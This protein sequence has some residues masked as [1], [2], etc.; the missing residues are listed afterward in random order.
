MRRALKN[1]LVV[2]LALILGGSPLLSSAD[3]A[4][5]PYW[6]PLAAR[7][8][9]SCD[10]KGFCVSVCTNVCQLFDLAQ[11]LI[12]FGITLVFFAI[13]PA[14]LVYGGIMILVSSGSDERLG[15][16]KKII[17]G[18]LIGIALALGAFLIVNT[19][20]SLLGIKG[21]PLANVQCSVSPPTKAAAP[22]PG[23]GGVLPKDAA[24]AGVT[25]CGGDPARKCAGSCPKAAD[26]APLVCA[27]N[28][29]FT[30][31]CQDPRVRTPV[32]CSNANP[33]GTCPQTQKCI[34]AG[35]VT[36]CVAVVLLPPPQCR[37][38]EPGS[39]VYERSMFAVAIRA[40][41]TWF[42]PVNPDPGCKNT[43]PLPQCY[44]TFKC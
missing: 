27:T 23:G 18:T 6:G 37:N 15:K 12:Y 14:F 42:A 22:K 43:P 36:K 41:D 44:R 21:I 4:S 17:T 35:G 30:R 32:A 9:L 34:T 31:Q 8:P 26:G 16:G 33:Q 13:G 7:C 1:F 3:H 40:C 19:F 2:V 29:D 10:E 39:C 5:F 24:C 38:V 20:I 25:T 11:H 28:P